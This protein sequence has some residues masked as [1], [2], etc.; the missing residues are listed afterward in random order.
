MIPSRIKEKSYDFSVELWGC[1]AE[2][3][4]DRL[5]LVKTFFY[6]KIDFESSKWY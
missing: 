2:F 6:L 3:L 1:Y 4:S 5:E